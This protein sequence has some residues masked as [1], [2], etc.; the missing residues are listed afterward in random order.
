MIG[1]WLIISCSSKS[2][3]GSLTSPRYWWNCVRNLGL[4][5]PLAGLIFLDRKPMWVCG[6][7][8]AASQTWKATNKGSRGFD[9][10]LF[11]FKFRSF[12]P[13]Q[14]PH[15]CWGGYM[16]NWSCQN[17]WCW[18]RGLERWKLPPLWPFGS[19]RE[20]QRVPPF[21]SAA[22]GNRGAGNR[23]AFFWGWE[24]WFIS[25]SHWS[26]GGM[27]SKIFPA[28]EVGKFLETT[29]LK[30]GDKCLYHLSTR[31]HDTNSFSRACSQCISF[32]NISI[33]VYIYTHTYKVFI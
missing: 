7:G 32:Y 27:N 24:P 22:A 33:C 26:T 1:N 3:H 25:A 9:E 21:P 2:A 20:A 13:P 31:I 16:G 28:M 8:W 19:G 5:N 11:V 15:D 14:K 30:G 29:Y 12:F 6:G 23:E 10:F 4:V 18:S 17:G